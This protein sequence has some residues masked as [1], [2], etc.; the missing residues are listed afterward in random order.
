MTV[1]P[2]LHV[3]P[4]PSITGSAPGVATQYAET[5]CSPPAQVTF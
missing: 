2:A 5:S 1:V 3:A 4:V